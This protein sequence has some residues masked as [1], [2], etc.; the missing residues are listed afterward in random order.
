MIHFCVC[1]IDL[2]LNEVNIFEKF[3]KIKIQMLANYPNIVVELL[4]TRG[5]HY[6]G[7]SLSQGRPGQS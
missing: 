5:K 3:L 6:R 1:I 4:Y 2:L 7:T